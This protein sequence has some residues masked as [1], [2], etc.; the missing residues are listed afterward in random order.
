[1][2]DKKV[3]ICLGKYLWRRRQLKNECAHKKACFVGV[4]ENKHKLID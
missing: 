4:V 1:M 2:A 3:G